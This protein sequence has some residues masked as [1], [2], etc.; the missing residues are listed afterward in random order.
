MK[1]SILKKK[2]KTN[3]ATYFD[4]NYLSK[5]LNLKNSIE[6]F[7]IDYKFYVL[8]LDDYVYKFLKKKNFVNVEIISLDEI[9]KKYKELK[10][11]KNKREIIEYYFT[12][13]PFLPKYLYEE[14]KIT[15]VI[16]IDTDYYFF[17]NPSK[18]II[19]NYDSSVIIIRQHASLKYGKYN[20]GLL[21]F[22]FNFGET[23][24]IVNKWSKQCINSCSDKVTNNSYAD[25]KYLDTWVNELK[26]VRVYEP[27]YTSLAPWDANIL[28]EKNIKKMIAFHFHALKL[29]HNHFVTGFHNFNKKNSKLILEKIYNPYV[30]N[31]KSIEKKYDLK[32]S[33]L[34]DNRKSTIGKFMVFF[35]NLKSNF[36]KILYSD[37]CKYPS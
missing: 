36:K 11:V 30:K 37:K 35:R 16:Y 15:H 5:F 19:A 12:L 7:N 23:Y 17:N 34:R 3:L 1:H 26:Y 13:S 28:I 32:S 20:V 10:V 14:R 31:L 6:Q 29:N 22:N 21:F 33:S 8:C 9:E 2:M 4:K 18:L 24:E 25:Q 27:E